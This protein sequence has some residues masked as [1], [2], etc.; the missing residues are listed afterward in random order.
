M[1]LQGQHE[2]IGGPASGSSEDE[3][4]EEEVRDRSE[5]RVAEFCAA[6]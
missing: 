2:H 3:E 6:T 5:R 4:E 1:T